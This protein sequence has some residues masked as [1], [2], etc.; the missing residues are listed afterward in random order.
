[1]IWDH[2]AQL[3]VM[4]PDGQNMVSHFWHFPYREIIKTQ[5]P[6]VLHTKSYF[7]TNK[8][9]FV[10]VIK[11]NKVIKAAPCLLLDLVWMQSTASEIVEQQFSMKVG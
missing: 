3:V 6:E 7:S 5:E 8:L 1:M 9:K 2:N 11:Q 4:L 10:K